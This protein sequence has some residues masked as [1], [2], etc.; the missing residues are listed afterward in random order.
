M[1]IST[2][3]RYGT[4]LLLELGLHY[5]KGPVFLKDIAK[6]EE[7][8]EKYLSQIM[9]T[10]KS[11]GFVNSFR[12]AQGGYI[13]ARHPAEITLKEIVEAL[14]GRFDLVE[15]V[16]NPSS[17]KRESICVT[18]DIWVEVGKMIAQVLNSITLEDLVKRCREKQEKYGM[19]NI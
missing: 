16:N 19:Y 4:R 11:A 17:C 13:L 3:A 5:G 1:K 6:N 2:R 12:G 18:R 15:C 7:I 9:I 8:S 10:V 14:E